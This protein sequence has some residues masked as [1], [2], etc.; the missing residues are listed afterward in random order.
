MIRRL[1][2]TLVPRCLLVAMA[3]LG[4]SCRSHA[5][6]AAR[7][8]V[9]RKLY[10]W[11]CGRVFVVMRATGGKLKPTDFDACFD[12]EGRGSRRLWI[13]GAPQGVVREDGY[14]V[15]HST[16][17][18][19]RRPFSSPISA[20]E[21]LFG[22][23]ERAPSLAVRGQ[24]VVAGVKALVLE[25]DDADARVTTWIDEGRAELLARVVQGGTGTSATCYAYLGWGACEGDCDGELGG[26]R[27][28]VAE[29][30]RRKFVGPGEAL[31]A[32]LLS[33][34]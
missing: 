30:R 9:T 13:E 6:A 22:D 1:S 31:C 17:P 24:Q 34:R 11:D 12:C 32:E 5:G 27:E 29:A 16:G 8:E 18:F 23:F 19:A 33:G 15:T 4:T 28:A 14:T 10:A 2:S 3:V 7:D 21:T 25:S 26:P 20:T